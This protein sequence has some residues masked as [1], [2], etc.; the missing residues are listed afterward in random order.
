MAD[1]ETI[2]ATLKSGDPSPPDRAKTLAGAAVDEGFQDEVKRLEEFMMQAI[3]AAPGDVATAVA[4]A[5]LG[6]QHARLAWEKMRGI[7]NA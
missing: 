4:R 7:I 1:T 5:T 3:T 6:Y 2:K